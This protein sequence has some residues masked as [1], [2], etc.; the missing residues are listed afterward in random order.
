MGYII[1]VLSVA[2]LLLCT[3]MLGMMLGYDLVEL[4]FHPLALVKL[5]LTRTR[6]HH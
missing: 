2:A 1:A 5:K 3:V 6:H 4:T